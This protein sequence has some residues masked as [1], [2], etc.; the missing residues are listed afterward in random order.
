VPISLPILASI[1]L[2]YA[3]DKWNEWWHAMLFIND[4]DKW[5]LQMMLREILANITNASISSMGKMMAA[6]YRNMNPLSTKMA[7]IV[8]TAVPIIL[9]YPYLQKYFT[10]GIMIG[11]L[12]E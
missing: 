12:K 7:A 1:A 9:V 10:R 8:I 2:F 6:K 5:P 3:V 11:S 4:K